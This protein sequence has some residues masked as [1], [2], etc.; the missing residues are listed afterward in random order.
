MKLAPF[1][2]F[3]LVLPT[4]ATLAQVSND[5]ALK[6]AGLIVKQVRAESYAELKDADIRLK[7]FRSESDY[8][9]TNFSISRALLGK[10]MR[11]FILVNP[12]VFDLKA[13]P[14]GLRAIIAHEL[15]HILYFNRRNRL[16]LAR[17]I[18]LISK[19]FTARFERRTDLKAISLGYAEGLKQYRRW[20]YQHVPPSS[21]DE[22]LRNYFSPDEIDAIA[23]AIK[24]RPELLDYWR[25]HV[26]RSL[27]EIQ[28][29]LPES[30]LPMTGISR[31]RITRITRQLMKTTMAR[32]N[33][34]PLSP[35][36]SLSIT[37]MPSFVRWVRI[38]PAT[39]PSASIA[40]IVTV[41][42]IK[43]NITATSSST[44]DP[45]LPHGSA[46]SVVKMYFD[47]SAPVNLKNS[48]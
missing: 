45:I 21:L 32:P 46:P 22:K 38:A 14:A 18:R 30:Q 2:L 11:Y 36:P 19:D 15:G 7:V 6:Q 4:V 35:L 23:S 39:A 47:S 24:T 29:R 5:A 34:S 43:S 26:P 9:R 12:R 41:A 20:L 10:K 27:E 37:S 13:P 48:V 33:K 28:A 8:F 44:P 1:L 40:P 16:R 42:G 31:R 17:L 25:K 3:I